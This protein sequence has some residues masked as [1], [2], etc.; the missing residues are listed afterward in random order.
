MQGGE[1]AE[2][3]MGLFI[4]TLPVRMRVGEQGAEESV[5][6][7]HR[8]LAEL[9]RHEHASLALA[10]RCSG[11]PA[12][13]PLFTSLLNYRHSAGNGQARSEEKARAWEGIKGLYGEERTNYPVTLSVDDLGEGFWMRA[14]VDASVDAKRVCQYMHMALESLVGALESEPYQLLGT[15]DVLPEWEYREIV[16]WNQTG[17]DYPQDTCLHQLFQAQVELTPDAVALVFGANMLSYAGLNTR[18][19]QLAHYLRELGVGPD[20]LVGICLERSLEMMAAIFGVLKAGGAYVPLDPAYPR[21][22]LAF[23]LEDSKVAILL[24]ERRLMEAV[25]LLGIG[26]S[27]ESCDRPCRPVCLEE[28]EADLARES[29]ENPVSGVLPENAAYVIYTSGSTGRPKGVIIAHCAINNHMYWLKDHFD[30]KASDCFLQK[31]ALSFDAAGTEFYGPLLTGGKLIIARSG[32][33]QDSSYLVRIIAEQSVTIMQGVP[34]LLWILLE[35]PEFA[36]CRSLRRMISA[37]EA[38]PAELQER[39]RACV[40]AEL[41]NFYGPTEA[42]IDVTFWP[43]QHANERAIVPIGRPISNTQIYVLNS[44]LQ[45]CPVGVGGELYIGG[46]NLARCYLN[47]PE[48]SAERFIPNHIS[49]EA[50]KRLYKTGDRGRWLADGTIEILGEER[51]SGEDPGIS[52]RAGRDRGVPDAARRGEGSGGDRSRR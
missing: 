47:Q 15:L 28:I 22:R 29:G 38:L 6:G 18:A 40:S 9:M 49:Q 30:L 41:H 44:E 31:T 32:G 51:P 2:Q 13:A 8:Q 16:E 24:T 34:S 17:V 36:K 21:D 35:E 43:H 46:E 7:A 14:Q 50:G 10:Q 25:E 19:N 5:R 3:A 1:G 27:A 45:L 33:Q 39:F 4:N 26:D 20:V 11:V 37:G 23:M 52:N 48:S 42:A 12:P